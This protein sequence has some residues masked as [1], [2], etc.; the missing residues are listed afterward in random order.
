MNS[1]SH[2][3]V[4]TACLSRTLLDSNSSKLN[5]RVQ[6]PQLPLP[7]MLLAVNKKME[8]SHLLSTKIHE[9]Q[10]LTRFDKLF[11]W[12]PGPVGAACLL[13]KYHSQ[14]WRINMAKWAGGLCWAARKWHKWRNEH[15][16]CAVTSWICKPRYR[17]VVGW[18]L[19]ETEIFAD[20]E[21]LYRQCNWVL[22]RRENGRSQKTSRQSSSTCLC[23]STVEW[24]HCMW[25]KET[26]MWNWRKNN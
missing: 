3:H 10:Y 6:V 25:N 22:E 14:N 15:S 7:V 26:N 21:G 19:I 16:I 13:E 1:L 5:P 12:T 11:P 23:E 2:V 20:K 17:Q 18:L 24:E 4:A 8:V 9:T